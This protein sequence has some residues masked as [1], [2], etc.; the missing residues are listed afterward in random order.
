MDIKELLQAYNEAELGDEACGKIQDSDKKICGTIIQKRPL[1]NGQG[2]EYCLKDDI[3]NEEWVNGKDLK[4]SLN[5]AAP[6]AY[7]EN[8]EKAEEFCTMYICPELRKFAREYC[9]KKKGLYG[10]NFSKMKFEMLDCYCSFTNLDLVDLSHGELIDNE[11]QAYLTKLKAD[12]MRKL[13]VVLQACAMKLEEHM[14]FECVENTVCDMHGDFAELGIE[15]GGA[16]L[17]GREE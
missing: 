1:E 11:K 12:V 17:Y 14:G 9:D 16:Q 2:F 6:Q 8:L 15:L 4:E 7:I 5:E 3:G 13:K 10:P